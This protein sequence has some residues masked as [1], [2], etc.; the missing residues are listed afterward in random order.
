M[1]IEEYNVEIPQDG[2]TWEGMGALGTTP[3]DNAENYRIY[4]V[5][6]PEQQK[7][8][9]WLS[10]LAKEGK[11]DLRQGY[12]LD[13]ECLT[14]NDGSAVMVAFG[15]GCIAAFSPY[16]WNEMLEY[17]YSLNP[18]YSIPHQ[19]WRDKIMAI[20]YEDKD[21]WTCYRYELKE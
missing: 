1:K 20:P 18:V 19:E 6:T 4:L 21:G 3:V 7:Y 8:R 9:E 16:E 11:L 10:G 5:M 12:D 14:A 13:C 15:G 17:V 2:E